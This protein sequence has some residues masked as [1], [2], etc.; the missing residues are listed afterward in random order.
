[1]TVWYGCVKE[2]QQDTDGPYHTAGPSSH[3][4]RKLNHG[5]SLSGG[6]GGGG[7]SHQPQHI[8]IHTTSAAAAAAALGV[9]PHTITSATDAQKR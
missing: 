9:G 7:G 5:H 8:I 1:M 4:L 3:K 2:E 6:G